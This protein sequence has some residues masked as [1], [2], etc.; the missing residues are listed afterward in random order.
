MAKS[1]DPRLSRQ[2]KRQRLIVLDRD[3]HTCAYCGQDADQVDHV[4][5]VSKEP[6]S[7]IDLHNMVACCRRCNISKGNRSEA[8]F[9]ARTATPPV[10]REHPSPMTVSTVQAGPALGQPKQN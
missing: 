2:Y 10:F 5:P 3:G 1:G 9:L 4:I 8:V 7:A 6:N